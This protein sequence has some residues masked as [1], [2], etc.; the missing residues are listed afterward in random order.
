MASTSK[1][2]AL[3]KKQ[4]PL[5]KK[6]VSTSR[7]KDLLKNAFPLYGNVSSTLKNLSTSKKNEKIGVYNSRNMSRL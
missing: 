2:I 7:M 1:K 4:F 5:D 3:I 6:T